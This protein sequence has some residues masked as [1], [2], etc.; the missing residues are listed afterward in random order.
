MPSEQNAFA[1]ADGLSLYENVWLPNGEPASVLLVVHGFTEHGGRYAHL[2]ARL[3]RDGFAVAAMDLR[4]HGRSAGDRAY[5][6][7]FDQYVDDLETHIART[8]NRWPG[9]PLFLFGHSMGG[10]IVLRR[11][12][13]HGEDV[14][15]IVLSAPALR[16]GDGLFPLLRH[17]AWLVARV[18][19]HLK[20]VRLG[21]S[22]ISR[23]PDAVA[24]F[25]NDPLVFHGR[26]PLQTGAE[27]LRIQDEI[28]TYFAAVRV[29]L[30]L[31]QGTDDKVV[32]PGACRHLIAQAKSPDKELRLYKGFYH[33]ILHEIDGKTVLDDV[34]EWLNVRVKR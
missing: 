29:P 23:D 25:R 13:Q 34:A 32:D 30:L 15:G 7:R 6:D 1:A 31:L 24:E 19:P 16:I 9:K 22:R 4:G 27:I 2:A 5:V 14:R 26:F 33:G 3:N 8:K 10:T 28:Q 21:S 17:L 12:M 11:I 20:V 18:L